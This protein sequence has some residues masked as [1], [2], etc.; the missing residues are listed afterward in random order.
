MLRGFVLLLALV[1]GFPAAALGQSYQD[2]ANGLVAVHVKKVLE[3]DQAVGFE[4]CVQLVRR[5][6]VGLLEVRLSFW[7]T[8]GGMLAQ[9]SSVLHPEFAAPACRRILLPAPAR[10][11]GRWEISRLRFQ[12]NP[13]PQVVG[14]PVQEG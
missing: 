8:A 13:L 2:A 11:Y 10:G 5:E 14:R 7:G 4:V 1:G 12:R 3:A 9:A 6:N